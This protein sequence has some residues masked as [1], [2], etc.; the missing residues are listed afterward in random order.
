VIARHLRVALRAEAPLDVVLVLVA[1]AS[2]SSSSSSSSSGGL[3][4][5]PFNRHR[6]FTVRF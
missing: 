6:L 1:S 2:T 3:Q 5:T 4:P